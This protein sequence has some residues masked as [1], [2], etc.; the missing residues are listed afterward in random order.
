MLKAKHSRNYY[1]TDTGWLNAIYRNNKAYIDSNMNDR[2][3]ELYGS[4]QTAFRNLVK[5]QMLNE[6]PR[7]GR[8]Y[9]INQAI[10]RVEN[11][12]DLHKDWTSR[13]VSANNFKEV[14]KKDKA[15]SKKFREMT[16]KNGKYTAFDPKKFEWVGWYTEGNKSVAVYK[17]EDIYIIEK[18]SPDAG[19]GA[20]VRIVSRW[21]FEA[22]DGKSIFYKEKSKRR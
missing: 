2:W 17:Y 10:K 7:T 8:K 19:A 6:N 21:E 1:K 3:K 11:S 12:K 15:L 22:M 9:T 16:R 4:S 14:F 18:T 13:D 20:S 5:E